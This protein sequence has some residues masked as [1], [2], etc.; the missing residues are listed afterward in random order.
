MEDK[1]KRLSVYLPE[2]VKADLEQMAD[3]TGLSMTQLIV[4]ATHGLLANYKS[5]GGAIFAD[6]VGAREH[7]GNAWADSL[8]SLQGQSVR[9]ERYYG[10]RALEYEQVYHRQDPD[11]QRELSR[12]A[13]DLKER[14]RGCDVLEI[15]CGT[16]YWTQIVAEGCKSIVGVDIRPEVIEIARAKPWPP[17]RVEFLVGDAYRLAELNPGTRFDY[18]LANFWFSHIPKNKIDDFLAQFHDRLGPGASVYMADNVYVK[19]RGGELIVKETSEDTYKLRELADGTKHEVLKNYYSY[20]ELY[21]IFAPVADGLILSV[22]TSFWTVSYR[23]KGRKGK[24]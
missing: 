20:D 4:M 9:M 13:I 16:G 12:M 5:Q 17:G 22:G 14:L 8:A 10:A 6:L 21:A 1:T 24:P 19:G 2:R 15:A 18:G 3:E 23:V 7:R 11:Y